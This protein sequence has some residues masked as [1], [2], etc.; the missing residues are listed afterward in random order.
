MESFSARSN[1]QSWQQ[2]EDYVAAL[3]RRLGFSV[4]QNISVD[5]QQVDLLC[6]N[7]LSGIGLTRLYID[8][9]HTTLAE[10]KSVS[11][12]DVDQFIYS[13]RSRAE[14]NGWTA[15]IMVSNRPFT[16][17]A[18]AAAAKHINIHL[19]TIDDLHEEALRI[20]SY[21]YDTVHKYEEENKFIDF[22]PPSGR[23]TETEAE[24][25]DWKLLE[26]L[27][28]TWLCEDG[29]QQMCLFG[30]FGTGKTTFL[31]FLHYS[32]AKRYLTTPSVRIPLLIPLRRYYEAADHQE[33]IS[34]FFMQECGVNA[35]FSLFHNFLIN[36]RF[37]LLL[38][39]FD[40]MGAKSDPTIRKANY[41]KL[42]PLVEGR[43]KVLISCRPAYFI[44]LQETRSVFSFVNKQMGF[45]PA[46]KTGAMTEQLFGVVR[47]SDL[48][49]VFKRARSA[50]G[51]T[52]YAEIGLFDKKQIKAYLRKH[53]SDIVTSSN[54]DLD[55]MKLY[56]R[57]QEIYDLSDLAQRP[58]LLKLIVLT[59]PLFR[60]TADGMY[61]IELAGQSHKVPD[62][63]PSV[64]YSVYTE[65]ELER[66]YKKG[67]IR[68]L[69]ERQDK[70][71]AI[72]AIAFEMFRRDVV[73][74]DKAA[75]LRVIQKVFPTSEDDQ[76]YYLN[77]IR[78]CSFLSRDSQDAARFT[79]KSF[80]E[81]YAAT[82]IQL[83]MS[84]PSEAQD[85]LTIRP[86]SEEV[87]FFL[88]DNIASSSNRPVILGLLE[89]LYTHLAALPTPSSTCIQ[90]V[91]N[92]LN[93]AREPISAAKKIEVD[94]LSYQKLD[95]QEQKFEGS[96]IGIL[97]T[98]RSNFSKLLGIKSEFK[99]WESDSADIRELGGE[100]LD[101]RALRFWNT[102]IENCHLLDCTVQIDTWRKSRVG[103]GLF[104]NSRIVNSG[105]TLGHEWMPIQGRFENCIL[106]GLDFRSPFFNNCEFLDCTMIM[107][108]AEAA[109]P[110]KITMEGCRGMLLVDEKG[111]IRDWGFGLACVSLDDAKRIR[112]NPTAKYLNWDELVLS[113]FE[114]DAIPKNANEVEARLGDVGL[115]LK[116]LPYQGKTC[117]VVSP[118]IPNGSKCC[119]VKCDGRRVT[120]RNIETNREFEA[121]LRR[122]SVQEGTEIRITVEAG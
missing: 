107:C 67:K 42:A 2:H 48:G 33:I 72:A 89:R 69:I 29:S 93:Y 81:Y 8:C 10:N 98:I 19:K 121:A 86:L 57:I 14:N 35:Q 11:K 102:Q 119:I 84:S 5:G 70:V 92:V 63:T 95:L 91:L 99:R 111:P 66:E 73:A 21:L 117:F 36:G 53:N 6:E 120:F 58:L 46:L 103:R 112:K 9:K 3:Y 30:D 45:A 110:E 76:A 60:K 116:L 87:A 80:M 27:V 104:Q 52:I 28:K 32:F 51:M 15:G 49:S 40:E 38:D 83:A 113:A 50:L 75:L 44:S 79:H 43:S 100:T 118:D 13:F 68:W 85:L 101:C 16:Q 122:T 77:D 97:R 109:P 59:L 78:T 25:G 71:R 65:K 54:G 1:E 47:D 12:D 106:V 105:T 64:L 17:Y 82:Y 115:A 108:L 74:L 4:K 7:W 41:L 22:I 88:G 94:L 20:R 96:R 39:G 61:E 62:I 18:K 37:L 26:E 34:Q 114:P 24:S 90:N 31:E 55:A 56:E 23:E